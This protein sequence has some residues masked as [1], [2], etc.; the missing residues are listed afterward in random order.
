[1]TMNWTSEIMNQN[2]PLLFLC[3]FS[4][5]FGHSTRRLIQKISA[6]EVGSLSWLLLIMCLRSLW[7]CFTNAVWK[8]VISRLEKS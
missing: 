5:T 3:C 6:R 7:S 8:S 1:V 4:Q 2:I